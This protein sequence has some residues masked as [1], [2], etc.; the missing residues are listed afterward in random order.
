MFP[1][2]IL[3]KVENVNITQT[4]CY[5][6]AIMITTFSCMNIREQGLVQKW[7]KMHWPRPLSCETF[8]R[9]RAAVTLD[10]FQIVLVCFFL[11]LSVSFLVLLLENIAFKA[12]KRMV[13][14]NFPIRLLD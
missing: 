9:N 4:F 8:T 5:M 14:G 12:A 3:L 10:D 6:Y 1:N 11:S 7:K 13:I 2:N